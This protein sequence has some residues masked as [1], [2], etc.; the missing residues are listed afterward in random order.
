MEGSAKILITAVGVKSQDGM[1]RTMMNSDGEAEKKEKAS[2][3]DK[4][5]KGQLL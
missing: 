1:L 5:N 4:E 3:K 2:K